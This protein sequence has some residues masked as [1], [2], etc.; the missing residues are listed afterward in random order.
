M[1][2]LARPQYKIDTNLFWLNT[3]LFLHHKTAGDGSKS[4]EMGAEGPNRPTAAGP[5]ITELPNPQWG[6]TVPSVRREKSTR[7]CMWRFSGAQPGSGRHHSHLLRHSHVSTPTAKNAGKYNLIVS[8]WRLWIRI[9]KIFFFFFLCI[10]QVPV[11]G[12]G[13]QT[14]TDLL[15][16]SRK[17]YV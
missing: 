1:W 8:S 2:G 9:T 10:Q 11:R 4:M 13:L 3:R 5:A 16:T 7:E 14:W 17:I 15:Q 6:W 12:L